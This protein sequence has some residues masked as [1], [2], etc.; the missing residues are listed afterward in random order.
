MLL[1]IIVLP[2]VLPRQVFVDLKPGCCTQLAV[3][4]DNGSST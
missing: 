4:A 2:N 1:E 3:D